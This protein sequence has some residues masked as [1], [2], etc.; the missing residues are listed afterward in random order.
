VDADL[1]E[2]P[3]CVFVVAWLAGPG[4]AFEF[5]ACSSKKPMFGSVLFFVRYFFS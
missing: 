2:L 5:K 3:F 1:A 4:D